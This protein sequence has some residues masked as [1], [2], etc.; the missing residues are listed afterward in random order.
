MN[1]KSAKVLRR[2]V[3]RM[4]QGCAA[5][6]DRGPVAVRLAK[7]GRTLLASLDGRTRGR[8]LRDMRRA[9]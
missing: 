2:R 3:L 1:E 7:L 6:V 8:I 5:S 4:V 9:S